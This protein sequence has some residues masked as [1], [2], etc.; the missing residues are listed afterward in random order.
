MF[1]G[2]VEGCPRLRPLNDFLVGQLVDC[3]RILMKTVMLD[4]LMW[5]AGEEGRRDMLGL[6]KLMW[7][8]GEEGR[9]TCLDSLS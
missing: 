6:T 8:A 9:R 1:L 4:T 5:H 2:N 7:H 3:S